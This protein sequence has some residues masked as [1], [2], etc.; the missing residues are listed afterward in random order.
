MEGQRTVAGVPSGYIL[1]LCIDDEDDATYFRRSVGDRSE[2]FLKT[3]TVFLKT[4]VFSLSSRELRTSS[5]LFVD[6]RKLEKNSFEQ[7][8]IKLSSKLLD[9]LIKKYFFKVFL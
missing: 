3:T 6:W 8:C 1:V 2:S 4:A 9:L 5:L 7:M